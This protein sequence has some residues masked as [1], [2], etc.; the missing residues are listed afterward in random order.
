MLA[1]TLQVNNPSA[2]IPYKVERHKDNTF[3]HS[4]L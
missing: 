2:Y 3:G 1:Y 4:T